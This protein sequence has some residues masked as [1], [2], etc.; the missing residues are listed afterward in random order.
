MRRSALLLYVVLGVGGLI[1]GIV[2]GE[3]LLTRG[4][5]LYVGPVMALI[6]LILAWMLRTTQRPPDVDLSSPTMPTPPPK[7]VRPETV[8]GK[9][10][11]NV[12]A[13]SPRRQRTGPGKKGERP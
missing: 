2:L 8:V 1:V 12:S 5:G 4:S 9:P 7:R 13:S 10:K 3:L 6:G 11:V